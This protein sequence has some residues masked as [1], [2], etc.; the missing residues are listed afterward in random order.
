M[1]PGVTDTSPHSWDI[2]S[3]RDPDGV[4][5]AAAHYVAQSA[6]QAVSDHGSFTMAVSGG[7]TPWKMFADL[8]GEDMPWQNTTFY[9]V[10]ERDVPADSDGRNLTHLLAAL[11]DTDAAVIPMPVDETD[12]EFA[13]TKYAHLLPRTIDLIH[14]GLGPDGHTASLVPGDPILDVTDRLVAVTTG[15]Y[16]GTRRMS[17]TYPALNAAREVLWLVTGADKSAALARLLAHDPAIPAGRVQ[18]ARNVVLVDSS[19]MGEGRRSG[20]GSLSAAELAHP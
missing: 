2:R 1:D 9:Q 14:L 15:E 13:A 10:D 17:L 11:S 19:A 6:R 8:A 5:R 3:H 20:G 12:I 18:A 16:Q 7:R 4:A